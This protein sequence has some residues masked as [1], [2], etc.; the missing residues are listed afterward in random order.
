M[1]KNIFI[2]LILFTGVYSCKTRKFNDYILKPKENLQFEIPSNLGQGYQW[3]LLDTSR[4]SILAHKS[5]PNPDT[6]VS[7]DL[8]KFTLRAKRYKGQFIL[9]F[10]H[11]RPFDP[12]SDTSLSTKIFKKVIIK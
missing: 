7:T 12:I 1:H 10:Y 5:S 2:L 4:F 3:Q 11:R 8:E 6:S 9:V